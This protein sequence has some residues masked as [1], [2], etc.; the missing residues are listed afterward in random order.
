M[1]ACH[2]SSPRP[3]HPSVKKVSSTLLILAAFLLSSLLPPFRPSPALAAA[4]PTPISPVNDVVVT[5]TGSNGSMAAPPYAIPVFSWSSVSGA[6]SYRLQVANNIGFSPISLEVTTANT[7]YAPSNAKSFPDGPIYWRVRVDSPQAGEYSAPASFNKQWASPDNAPVLLSPPAGQKIDFFDFPMPGD[8]SVRGFTWKPVP[9]AG[10]YRFQIAS[11]ETGFHSPLINIETAATTYQ[12]ENKLEN[13]DY[14][15]RV[16]PLFA[17]TGDRLGTAS[18]VRAFTLAFGKND[19]SSSTPGEAQIPVLISPENNS[20]P[21]FTPTFRWTAVRGAEKY[22]LQYTSDPTCDFGVAGATVTRTTPNSAY[23]PTETLP[24][25]KEYCWHVRAWA[26]K[27]VSDWSPV[28]RFTKK[29]YI[30]PQPLTPALNYQNVKHPLFSWTPVPGA[31]Y[32]LIEVCED[33]DFPC[34]RDG[35]AKPAVNPFFSYPDFDWTRSESGIWYWRV[36]PY[37]GSNNEGNSSNAEY[38]KARAYSFRYDYS[39]LAPHQ[40]YPLYYY[41]PNTYDPPYDVE[42]NFTN[43]YEDR[44]VALPIFMWHKV[45]GDDGY[46]PLAYRVQLDD[47]PLFGLISGKPVKWDFVTENLSASPSLPGDF[48]PENDTDYYWRVCALAD[49]EDVNCS[50]PWSQVWRARFDSNL[51]PSATDQLT[52]MRPIHGSEH[53]ETTP[54]FEWKPLKGATRYTITISQSPSLSSPVLQ[55]TVVRPVYTSPYSLAQRNLNKLN[56]GTYYWKVCNADNAT[57]CSPTWRFQIAAQSQWRATRDAGDPAN[58]LQIAADVN[59]PLVDSNFELTNLTVSQDKDYWYF[60]FAAST[61]ADNMSYGIYIDTDHKDNSGAAVNPLTHSVSAIAAHLPE[62]A[63]YILQRGGVFS[64]AAVLLYTSSGS[65]WISSPHILST[66]G[67]SLSYSDGH[68]ELK[69]PRAE[70]GMGEKTGSMALSLFSMDEASGTIKDTVPAS[71]NLSTLDRFASV[72][73]RLNIANPPTNAGGDPLTYPSILPFF[74]HYPHNTIWSGFT[75]QVSVD[76]QFNTVLRDYKAVLGPPYRV[77][78]FSTEHTKVQD[79]AGDNTYFWRVR[80]QYYP[81]IG[82]AWSQSNRFERKGFLP[83]N[84][85][86]SISFATPTFSWDISEG[87]MSYDLQVDND[88]NFGSPEINVTTAQNSYT[89]SDTLRNGLYYWRVRIS[90]D[91]IQNSDKNWSD[92]KVF[93]LKLPVP[94]NLAPH[95]PEKE[96]AV[97]TTPTF[98]WS[99]VMENDEGKPV[100]AAWKYRVEVSKDPAFSPLYDNITTEQACWTPTKGYED[101]TYFWRVALI[102]GKGKQGPFS[103]SATFTKQ[104]RQPELDNLNGNIFVNGAPVFSWKAIPGAAQYRIEIAHN[105]SFAPLFDAVTTTSTVYIP[106]KEYPRNANYYW[107]VAMIDRNGKQGPFTGSANVIAPVIPDGRII[108]LPFLGGKK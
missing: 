75:L 95:I 14:Y 105:P 51:L 20:Q 18:E 56:F 74:F 100:F 58:R 91:G 31:K 101:G 72:S 55:E 28:W 64:S 12:P 50:T 44:T 35:F 41:P 16:I 30:Q 10:G 8:V 11:S 4:S 57:Q 43:L 102:D 107:R 104:Y 45:F 79:V 32:Y 66:Q 108:Y 48:Q 22:E 97:G 59:D 60:G 77:S 34:D 39:S 98:C 33:D 67:G 26:G 78:P 7:S 62:Y 61:E 15:W 6:K 81:N 46:E 17:E 47:E 70:I 88:S 27:S 85:D 106:T 63:V 23:T 89:H 19:G 87:A 96:K 84:L 76:E 53:I 103:P 68:L 86:T 71:T 42:E 3:A 9:G 25:D 90:R 1:P 38:P 13:G 69:I 36:T 5:A 83:Q 92:V 99:P 52:L 49:P 21:T 37:D 24:N 2:S 94:K 65:G 54:L 73:E 93:D 80:N 40:F 29:W 82:G